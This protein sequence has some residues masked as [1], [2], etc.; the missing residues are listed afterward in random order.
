MEVSDIK[1]P[2]IDYSKLKYRQDSFPK[3]REVTNSF[4]LQHC[5]ATPGRYRPY[6]EY[7][8]SG[9]TVPVV[10]ASE[11]VEQEKPMSRTLSKNNKKD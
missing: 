11:E 7:D 6:Y 2:N 8:T 1:R 5:P 3:R 4:Y 9:I 10:G